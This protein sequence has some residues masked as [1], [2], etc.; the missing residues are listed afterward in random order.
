D[1]D[2]KYG[3]DTKGFHLAGS[4]DILANMTIKLG[5]LNEKQVSSARRNNS[6]YFQINYERDIPDFGTLL[7][8]NRLVRVKDDI[9][10]YAITLR[11]GEVEATE[12]RD[13]LDFYDSMYNT[14][15]LQLTYTGIP[16]LKLITKYLLSFEKHYS[17]KDEDKIRKDDPST[18]VDEAI[19]FM[20]EDQQ[21][22]SSGDAREYTFNGMDPVLAF[23]QANWIPRR[24]KDATVK[25]NTFI[26]K[27]SYELPVGKLPGI[28]A[29]AENLTLTPMIKWVFERN[30]DRKWEERPL[31]P[32]QV[33]P[34]D[35]QSEEYLRFNQNTRETIGLIRLDYVFTPSLNILGGFQYRRLL[36]M[37]ENYKLKFLKPWG[38]DVRTPVQW[39][40]DQKKR[41]WALQA[42]NQGEWLGFNIR[43]LVG[44]KKTTILP[45]ILYTGKK[46]PKTT[47]NE[48]YVRALM[49]F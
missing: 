32:T 24:Y 34:T 4:Y 2:Y 44:Y 15:T 41:I 46:K 8:Q 36:N 23:D 47:S 14:T 16:R 1:P 40:A 38:E 35:Y 37:D 33:S 25:F 9:I 18:K 42:I 10:D 48:T 29:F 20:L 13:E 12:V 28:R 11:V 26:I 27:S 43:I 3:A 6:K 7:F 19:D 49:G 30:W 5:W 21:L 45:I 31:D 22:R 17:P 39:R